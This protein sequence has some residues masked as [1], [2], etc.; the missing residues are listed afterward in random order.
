[1]K[2]A[3]RRE[4]NCLPLPRTDTITM[5][6]LTG[7]TKKDVPRSVFVCGDPNRVK[8]IAA[9]LDSPRELARSREFVSFGGS[10]GGT[11]TLIISHGVGASGAAICFQELI[12]LGAE[13]IVR[14]GTAGAFLDDYVIGDV[15]IP[16]GAF[17][18]EGASRAMVQPEYPAVPDFALAST[19]YQALAR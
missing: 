7:L 12:E 4:W 10:L 11:K 15:F 18:L 14:L 2:N 13:T 9:F 17:R 19:I 16:M 1:M 3:R 6:K 8:G 5:E